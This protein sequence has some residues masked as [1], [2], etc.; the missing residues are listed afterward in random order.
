MNTFVSP[1]HGLTYPFTAYCIPSSGLSG[2]VFLTFCFL[3][4]STW[5]SMLILHTTGNRSTPVF[6][7]LACRQHRLRL[8]HNSD[9]I[10]KKPAYALPLHLVILYC[11]KCLALVFTYRLP[12]SISVLLFHPLCASRSVDTVVSVCA[13]SMPCQHRLR[14]AI[15]WQLWR[16]RFCCWGGLHLHV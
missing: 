12:Y 11:S 5:F 13:G 4:R 14:S 3:Y 2:E 8:L 15:N 1:K 10:I 7:P 9:R 16:Y 6:I